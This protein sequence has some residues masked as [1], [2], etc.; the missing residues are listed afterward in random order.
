MIDV[1]KGIMAFVAIMGI[2]FSMLLLGII[3]NMRQTDVEELQRICKDLYSGSKL[4]KVG[5]NDYICIDKDNKILNSHLSNWSTYNHQNAM[6]KCI[7]QRKEF[8]SLETWGDEYACISN[9]VLLWKM[10]K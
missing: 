2:A 3:G 4:Q 8:S 10:P 6:I 1:T 7:T 9:K 5:G